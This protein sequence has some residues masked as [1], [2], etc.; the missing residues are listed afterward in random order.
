MNPIIELNE[1]QLWAAKQIAAARGKFSRTNG[2]KTQK[3]D[4]NSSDVEIDLTGVLV[5]LA[6]SLFFGGNSFLSFEDGVDAGWDTYIG[7][8]KA[9]VKATRHVNGKLLLESADELK[10]TDI[11]ILAIVIDDQHIKLAGWCSRS[12]FLQN[13]K[14]FNQYGRSG[15]AVEQSR[16]RDIG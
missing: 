10:D 15:V 1:P 12:H 9:Q 11:A 2:V 13:C 4:P 3:V 8:L 14:P 6:V 16:L 7:K 5:E